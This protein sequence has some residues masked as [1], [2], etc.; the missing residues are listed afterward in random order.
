M[1]AI[2]TDS[3]SKKV[4]SAALG[5][6]RVEKRKTYLLP[7]SKPQTLA[8]CTPA[9]AGLRNAL[10]AI[11]LVFF[12]ISLPISLSMTTQMLTTPRNEGLWW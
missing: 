5:E 6:G 1:I 8:I 7:N 3:V 9:E 10:L 12:A 4:P 2:Y 11:N